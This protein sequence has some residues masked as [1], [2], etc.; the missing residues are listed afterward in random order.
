MLVPAF[1]FIGFVL[2]VASKATYAYFL[3]TLSLAIGVR[4]VFH[5]KTHEYA[6]IPDG[7]TEVTLVV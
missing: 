2:S 4:L 3:L 1:V 7:L 6:S 5:S